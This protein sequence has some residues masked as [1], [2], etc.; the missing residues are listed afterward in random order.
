MDITV[1]IA[2]K[3]TTASTNPTANTIPLRDSGGGVTHGPSTFSKLTL[4]GPQLKPLPVPITGTA[5]LT[6]HQGTILVD[7]TGG[8]FTL[9]LAGAAVVN[10]QEL[11]IIKLDAANNVTIASADLVNGAATLVLSTQWKRTT[12]LSNGST[13]YAG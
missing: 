7:G 1:P 6:T 10:Q 8:A 4:T 11:V 3:T 5:T 2:Q 9:T 13:Y 12:I